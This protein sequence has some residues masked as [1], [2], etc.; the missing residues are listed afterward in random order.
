MTP[1]PL[2][3]AILASGYICLIVLLIFYGLEP[4]DGSGLDI[5][6][7]IVMLSLFVLSAAVMGYLFVFQSAVLYLEGKHKEAV[8]FFL[9]T[10]GIFA[11]ITLALFSIVFLLTSFP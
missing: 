8:A 10:A 3:N 1:N 2:Y 4:V 9:K 11:L 5:F 7:P 6:I